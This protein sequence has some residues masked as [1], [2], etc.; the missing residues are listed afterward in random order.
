MNGIVPL[1]VGVATEVEA[2]TSFVV[3]VEVAPFWRPVTVTFRVPVVGPPP[4]F[5]VQVDVGAAADTVKFTGLEV[6]LFRVGNI[7]YSTQVPISAFE[8]VPLETQLPFASVVPLFGVQLRFCNPFCAPQRV[9][10]VDVTLLSNESVQLLPTV[11]FVDVAPGTEIANLAPTD[12][13][14]GVLL[15]NVNVTSHS[16]LV[17]IV[18]A[19]PVEVAMV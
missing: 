3:I 1:L 2:V 5:V 7:A 19:Q 13:E 17:V 4:Q 18:P 10:T 16:V 15:G 6:A 11:K 12:V 9:K 8:N 14:V